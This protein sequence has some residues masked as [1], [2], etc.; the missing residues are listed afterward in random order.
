M[1]KY[2]NRHIT[3]YSYIYINIHK[4]IPICLH[5]NSSIYIYTQ[6]LICSFLPMA[7]PFVMEGEAYSFFHTQKDSHMWYTYTHVHV[8]ID[9]SLPTVTY[10]YICIEIYAHFYRWFLHCERPL[11]DSQDSH[12]SPQTADRSPSEAALTDSR[13]HEYMFINTY[14]YI[15]NILNTYLWTHLYM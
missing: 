3:I 5:T 2:I 11:W 12:I 13:N 9:M 6:I 8:Y 1:W 4:H 7:S 15:W 10:I 14:Q